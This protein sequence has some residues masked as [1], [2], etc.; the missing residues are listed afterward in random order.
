[1]ATDPPK[2]SPANDFRPLTEY[3]R[4]YSETLAVRTREGVRLGTTD[5]AGTAK[6]LL[7]G[8]AGISDPADV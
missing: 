2:L 1:M 3:G 6:D 7:T 5:W 8:I 4:G